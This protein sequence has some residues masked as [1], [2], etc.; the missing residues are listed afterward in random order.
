MGA[1]LLQWA[2]QKYA[3]R[4]DLAAE[5]QA[6]SAIANSAWRCG[7]SLL[8]KLRELPRPIAFWTGV[9]T[10]VHPQFERHTITDPDS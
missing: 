10:S 7:I 8:G 2:Y 3:V 5:V 6:E 4:N 1:L 9:T